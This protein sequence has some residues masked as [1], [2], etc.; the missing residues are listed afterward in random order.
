MSVVLLLHTLNDKTKRIL[1]YPAN[2][3]LPYVISY[4]VL[5]LRQKCRMNFFTVNISTFSPP[6]LLFTGL[7]REWWGGGWGRGGIVIQNHGTPV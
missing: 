2:T 5:L 1:V 4:I 6:P 3:Y 7:E